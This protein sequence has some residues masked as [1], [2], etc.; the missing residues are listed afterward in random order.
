ME[1]G[2]LACVAAQRRAA[3][4]V[5][6][7]DGGGTPPG[8]GPQP[9]L[10]DLTMSYKC[11]VVLSGATNLLT[12]HPVTDQKK[13]SS[14]LVCLYLSATPYKQCIG[15]LYK[16]LRFT[17]STQSS[18]RHTTAAVSARARSKL[19]ASPYNPRNTS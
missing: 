10:G 1:C 6:C 14:F 15:F 19:S 16:L 13:L 4:S 2:M 3:R 8:A 18:A 11:L 7:H 9:V 5:A 12:T 17:Q